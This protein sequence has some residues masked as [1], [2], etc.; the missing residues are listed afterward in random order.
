MIFASLAVLPV[1]AAPEPRQEAREEETEEARSQEDRAATLLFNTASRLYRQESW[2][3]AAQA[4]GEFL[5]RFPRHGDAGEA[6]FARGYCFHRLGKHAESAADLERA[7]RDPTTRWAPD[8]CFYL[9]R[10][11]EALATS[12]RPGSEERTRGLLAAAASYQKATKLHASRLKKLTARGSSERR[13]E[14]VSLEASARASAGEALYQAGSLVEA[15]KELAPFLDDGTRYAATDSYR[16]GLYFMA[17]SHHGLAKAGNAHGRP[18]MAMKGLGLLAHPSAEDGPLWAEASY[19]LGRWLQARGEPREALK[20]YERLVRRGGTHSED[21]VY[22]HALALYELEDER[23]LERAAGEFASFRD[24]H[25]KH[26]LAARAL[27][28]EALCFFD[29]E[30]YSEAASRL[31]SVTS[32]RG[33]H[34]GELE[35]QAWLGLGQARLLSRPPQPALAV[36]ALERAVELCR[37]PGSRGADPERVGRLDQA[38]YWRAEALLAEGGDSLTRAA[39]AFHDLTENST[40]LPPERLEEALY[41]EVQAYFR[42]S[43]YAECADAARRYRRQYPRGEGRFFA[44]ALQVAARNALRAPAGELDEKERR[45][46]ATYFQQ[47]AALTEDEDEARSLRYS[48]GVA[49]YNGDEFPR[50][51]KLLE[52][53]HAALPDETRRSAE[54]A[55]LSFFLADALAQ[56]PLPREPAAEDIGR[57][58]RAAG[59][60]GEYLALARTSGGSAARHAATARINQGLCR[61]WAGDHQR[62]AESFAALLRSHPEHA[63]VHQVCFWLGEAHVDLGELEAATKAYG[64]AARETDDGQFAARALLRAARIESRRKLPASALSLVDEALAKLSRDDDSDDLRREARF[65]RA[66]ALVE[67]ERTGEAKQEL[68]AFLEEFPGSAFESRTRLR[69]A[70]LE[71]DDEQPDRAL[72]AV[73]PLTEGRNREGRDEALYIQ[74]W[75][76]RTLADAAAVGDGARD[77]KASEN[78]GKRVRHIGSMEAAYRTLIHDYPDGDFARDARLE[79]GEHFFNSKAYGEAR[80]WFS[81]LLQATSGSPAGSSEGAAGSSRPGLRERGLFGLAFVSFEEKKYGEARK[82]FDEVA[83]RQDGDLTARAVFYAGRAWMLSRGDREAV[84]RFARL[85]GDL[86]QRGRPYAEESL[87]RLGECHQRLQEH[88]KAVD[89]LKGMLEQFPRGKLRHEGRFAL[90]FALQYLDRH[91]AAEKAFRQVVSATGDVIAARAQYHIGECYMDQGKHRKAAREF[92]TVVANFDGDGAYRD[93]YRRALLAAGIAYEAAGDA[94]S[95]KKQWNELVERFGDSTEGRAAKKRL[96]EVEA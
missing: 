88:E 6:C 1:S 60:F 81:A 91:G 5:R 9:G 43:R 19:L 41:K 82:L 53:V 94:A 17:L 40:G 79:L 33:L 14:L 75:C 25:S 12:R 51:V 56:Q 46:A 84:K 23:S 39:E 96:R 4:F 35:A 21:A 47:A 63:L 93:W 50:A 73:R 76:H 54:Y 92:L 29:R 11:L 57:L 59:L 30:H 67:S 77:G 44:D 78:A 49:L 27:F 85:T 83:K 13:R 65:Q 86:R 36:A 69:L 71:L 24:R 66:M 34:S 18:E 74:A 45:A 48:A 68:V 28:Y 2:R 42:A 61:R 72:R 20:L 80:K 87:L 52:K 22:Y 95:A 16:R 70:H 62:A 58:K 10:S 89:V 55:D 32:R 3:E 90:G 31:E 26:P 37:K 8:A 15:A 64:R 38:L 7:T